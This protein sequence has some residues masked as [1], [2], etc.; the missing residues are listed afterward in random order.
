MENTSI[1]PE[2]DSAGSDSPVKI[3][4]SLQ[5][6]AMD[7]FLPKLGDEVELT[8]KGMVKSIDGDVACISPTEVNGE[9]APQNPEAHGLNEH[10]KLMKAANEADGE[11]YGSY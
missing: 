9:P 8:V 2:Q 5:S 7:G 11:E 6:L 4:A 1:S 10:D 3:Y